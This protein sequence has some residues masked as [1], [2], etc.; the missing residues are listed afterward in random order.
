MGGRGEV[1]FCYCSD[2]GVAED[3]PGE[4]RGGGEEKGEEDGGDSVHGRLMKTCW[5]VIGRIE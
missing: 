5:T 2:G 3:A 4:G 1:V